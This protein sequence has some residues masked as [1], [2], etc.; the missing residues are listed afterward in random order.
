MNISREKNDPWEA[1]P[2]TASVLD[3]SMCDLANSSLREFFVT[4]KAGAHPYNFEDKG[5]LKI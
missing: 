2:S 3:G 1:A 4:S 5:D